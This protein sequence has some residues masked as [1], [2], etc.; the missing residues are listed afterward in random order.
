MC[1]YEVTEENHENLNKDSKIIFLERKP[2]AV[3]SVRPSWWWDGSKASLHSRL[4]KAVLPQD[5]TRTKEYT[6]RHPN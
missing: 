6:D 3:E 5:W 1:L 4:P 2:I